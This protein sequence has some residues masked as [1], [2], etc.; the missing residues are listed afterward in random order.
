MLF[1]N[2]WKIFPYCFIFTNLGA[3][4]LYTKP[5]TNKSTI[6]ANPVLALLFILFNLSLGRMIDVTTKIIVIM[7]KSLLLIAF[8]FFTNFI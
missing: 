7:Y 4:S 1:P 3:K 5:V 2:I 6:F 8:T